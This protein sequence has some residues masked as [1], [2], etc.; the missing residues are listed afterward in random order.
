MN[1]VKT[2]LALVLSVTLSGFFIHSKRSLAK[3][4]TVNWDHVM[5]DIGHVLP[6]KTQ[7]ASF[8]FHNNSSHP[9]TI[10]AEGCCGITSASLPETVVPGQDGVFKLQVDI[11]HHGGKVIKN[12]VVH[13]P[14]SPKF[15]KSLQIQYESAGGW[16]PVPSEINFGSVREGT[17]QVRNFRIYRDEGT[18]RILKVLANKQFI[19]VHEVPC[20]EKDCQKFAVYLSAPSTQNEDIN[21]DLTIHTGDVAY[22]TMVVAVVAKLQIQVTSIPEKI[23]LGEIIR[24]ES[25]SGTLILTGSGH[26]FTATLLQCSNWMH[27][28][29]GPMV[30]N[31]RKL[32]YVVVAQNSGSLYDVVKLRISTKKDFDITLPVSGYVSKE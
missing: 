5:V 24:G 27:V 23:K 31:S 28:T 9:L 6:G 26:P 3:T 8:I 2:I 10:R 15:E 21:A 25:Y 22:K 11:Q 20:L 17:S 29:I 4:E 19:T 12:F 18:S 32:N 1:K 13:A 14:D 30:G 16:W 7:E